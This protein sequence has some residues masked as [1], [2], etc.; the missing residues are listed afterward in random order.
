MNPAT[1]SIRSA[2]RAVVKY[3]TKERIKI[4]VEETNIDDT[5]VFVVS[6]KLDASQI[7]KK[8]S[9]RFSHHAE[10]IRSIS[11]FVYV[12]VS[13][14]ETSAYM[15]ISVRDTAR[16]RQPTPIAGLVRKVVMS[17][18]KD[19]SEHSLVEAVKPRFIGSTPD[20]VVVVTSAKDGEAKLEAVLSWDLLG[21]SIEGWTL[22]TY[23]GQHRTKRS[24][25][26]DRLTDKIIIRELK[27]ITE[28][29]S[30]PL[31]CAGCD[32]YVVR[33][34]GSYVTRTSDR[35]QLHE[36]VKKDGVTVKS[37][38]PRNTKVAFVSRMTGRAEI[39]ESGSSIPEFCK[40]INIA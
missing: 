25:D 35:M 2:R 32:V 33:D 12:R 39:R 18:P 7:L 13:Q 28:A 27:K 10:K 19:I 6:D 22:F 24:A 15:K 17:M 31:E 34:D 11:P 37:P 3:L 1:N 9:N 30:D 8:P 26:F 23:W 29:L 4:D 16:R 36:V 5:A 40:T 38:S 21:N 20:G 14:D